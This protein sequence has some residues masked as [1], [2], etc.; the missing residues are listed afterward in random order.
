MLSW[1][2]LLLVLVV[3]LC[4][5]SLA[6]ADGAAA[7]KKKKHCKKDARVCADGSKVYRNIEY[8]CEYDMCPEEADD[9]ND[10]TDDDGF[11]DDDDDAKT[12]PTTAAPSSCDL[13]CPRDIDYKC[14]SDGKT[15]DNLCLL[16]VAMC[17]TP[18]I[19]LAGAGACAP[20]TSVAAVGAA[21]SLAPATTAA[22]AASS[23]SCVTPCLE[24]LQEVCGSNGK[25]YP[26]F[27]ELSNAACTEM[28]LH[29][30]FEGA[31]DAPPT[32]LR[33][34][35]TAAAVV[36][37]AAVPVTTSTCITPCPEILQQVCGSDKKTYDNHCALKNAICTNPALTLV[38]EGAC[39]ATPVSTTTAV[40]PHAVESATTLTTAAPAT[41]PH[42]HKKDTDAPAS[43][44]T[45]ASAA[46]LPV[47]PASNRPLAPTTWTTVPTAPLAVL[48]S[49]ARA[50]A[51]YNRTYAYVSVTPVVVELNATA[52]VDNL[53]SLYHVIA[54]VI[55]RLDDEMQVLDG[56]FSLLLAPAGGAIDVRDDAPVSWTLT[57]C[58]LY[59]D[60]WNTFTNWLTVDIATG[61]AVCE[62]PRDKARFDKQPLQFAT[63]TPETQTYLAMAR[64]VVHGIVQNKTELAGAAIASGAVGA[65]LLSGLFGLVFRRRHQQA[66][67]RADQTGDKETDELESIPLSQQTPNPTPAA[68][69]L[70]DVEVDVAV[71][72]TPRDA[73]EGQFQ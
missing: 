50:F 42:P 21:A 59:D 27:C 17:K 5:A 51:P 12:A 11:V 25:T 34:A 46:V 29:P 55:V 45:T 71:E 47:L 72:P 48:A 28:G 10:D 30:I 7:A 41:T 6:E 14:G 9:R 16:Q 38:M 64:D 49:V 13:A 65:L 8:D 70:S 1:R 18:T 63:N 66:A 15:Y 67:T 31:C 73:E 37:A 43:T 53:P 35:T 20:S 40:A 52:T 2:N 58:S 57:G 54:H 24:I 26:N 36:A 32:N 19:R 3:A 60:R 23:S 69:T 61:A 4:L 68:K 44:T 22:A 39:A 33:P 56:R 62:T